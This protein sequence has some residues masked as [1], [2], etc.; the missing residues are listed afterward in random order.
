M[1]QDE[2][3]AQLTDVFRA[4]FKNPDLQIAAEMTA[5]D[6]QGWDSLAHIRLILGV[7]KSFGVKF[8]TAEVSSFRNVGDLVALIVQKKG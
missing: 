2:I 4:Q 6:M 1:T 8:K 5:N 7:E 3:Y